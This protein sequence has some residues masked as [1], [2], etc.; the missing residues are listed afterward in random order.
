MK[1]KSLEK[2]NLKKER[3]TMMMYEKTQHQDGKSFQT[4]L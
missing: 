3:Y 1:I 2:G 4:D